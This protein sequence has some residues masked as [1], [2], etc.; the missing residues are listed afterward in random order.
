MAVAAQE[1]ALGDLLARLRQRPGEPSRRQAEALSS[2]IDV[3][4]GKGTDAAVV[5]AENTSATRLAN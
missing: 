4:E 3:V 5:A 1:D 2:R